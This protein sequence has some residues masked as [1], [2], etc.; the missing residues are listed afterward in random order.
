ME[1]LVALDRRTPEMR[2]RAVRDESS[3]W[4][5]L[6]PE[7][8]GAVSQILHATMEDELAALL[9][10]R[11]YERTLDRS[12]YRNGR[13]R[14]WLATEIGAIELSVPRARGTAY[15]PSFLE[16][17]ARRTSTVDELP[18]T[19]FLRG[20]STR[21]TAALAE[22]LTG[23]SLSAAAISRLSVQL[24]GQVAGF[25][26]RRIGLS[27]R[28][29][30]LDGLWVS[31]RGS[32]GRAS[33]RVVLAAY[34]ISADG[35]R[36]LLDYRQALSESAWA[37]GTLLRSLVGKPCRAW[38]I[39]GSAHNLADLDRAKGRSGDRRLTMAELSTLAASLLAEPARKLAR[40]SGEDPDRVE[41][42]P[43]G[44]LIIAAILA[45][46]GLDELTVVPEG[47]RDGMVA[48]AFEHGDGWWQDP[49]PNR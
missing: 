16:R 4:G 44:L 1:S 8:A 28:Y 41:I 30:L 42:L 43:P 45:H 13:S 35:S 11:P 32:D 9:A 37:W 38:A 18:R 48:A 25:H 36:E 40:R 31:V 6:R 19:A 46:Y 39:G 49:L 7:L 14:R 47:L 2:W 26:R 29:L 3:L 10:A 34:G 12:G 17:A 23:V 33:K 20:L 5:D 24:D 21:E 22:R 15:R 27:V